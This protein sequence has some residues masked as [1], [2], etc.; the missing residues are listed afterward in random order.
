MRNVI[1]WLLAAAALTPALQAAELS[2]ASGEILVRGLV[3]AAGVS[4]L[5]ITATAVRAAGAA[6]DTLLSER[7]QKQVTITSST[8]IVLNTGGPGSAS[9]L[10]PGAEIAAVG[11]NQGKGKALPARAIMVFLPEK[12][13]AGSANSPGETPPA[14]SVTTGGSRPAQS[15]WTRWKDPAGFSYEYP[16]DWKALASAG[17]NPASFVK[18]LMV[19][20]VRRMPL[21]QGTTSGSRA[22]TAM[23]ATSA[24]AAR[25]GWLVT[26]TRTMM[27]GQN[28]F[29]LS[30]RGDMTA[31][32]V[33]QFLGARPGGG[34][35]ASDYML[36][37]LYAGAPANTGR[38]GFALEVGIAAP[39][40][41]SFEASD[42]LSR[43]Q[44]SL[45]YGATVVRE[46]PGFI[47]PMRVA[48]TVQIENVLKQIGMA[49]Q[50]YFTDNND[51]VP[52][53]WAALEPYDT[54]AFA[55]NIKNGWPN[56][57]V[58]PVQ[59]LQ[60][61]RRLADLGNPAA[62]PVARADGPGFSVVLYA[63]G[64]VQKTQTR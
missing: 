42:I 63:D 49:M 31:S 61:G 45:T 39:E 35:A 56:W 25:Q 38:E 54:A 23:R 15:V 41:S 17:A 40:A 26:E 44:R 46:R 9:D 19:L 55:T 32:Q 29:R 64:H 4:S 58:G 10:T 60:P 57:Q 27:A 1:V 12:P 37:L 14:P 2:P 47:G 50:L 21:D 3:D 53:N 20:S 6:E 28:G 52:P 30:M 8:T 33:A 11:P 7:V 5:T 18:G 24:E 48:N 22:M 34:D 59:L 51:V 36:T 43:V 13:P 62:T 16:A